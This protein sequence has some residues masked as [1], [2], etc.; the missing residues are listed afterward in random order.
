MLGSLAKP[1]ESLQESH[2]GE[3][4]IPLAIAIHY[5]A[6]HNCRLAVIWRINLDQIA[7]LPFLLLRFISYGNLHKVLVGIIFTFH[8]G[9]GSD[10][11]RL[12]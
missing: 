10:R 11:L 12:V 9:I 2:K 8:I 6:I 4:R 5:F 7:V 1:S 3:S